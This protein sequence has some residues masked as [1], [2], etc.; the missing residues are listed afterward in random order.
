M[1]EG[2]ADV[3]RCLVAA[4]CGLGAVVDAPGAAVLDTCPLRGEKRALVAEAREVLGH[5]A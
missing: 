3:G 2:V 4:L 5:V 1:T